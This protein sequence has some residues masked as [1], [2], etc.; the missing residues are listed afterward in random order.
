MLVENS[1]GE[2]VLEGVLIQEGFNSPR[3]DRHF[4]DLVDCWSLTDIASEHLGN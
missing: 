1:V 3:N 4:Q 2:L